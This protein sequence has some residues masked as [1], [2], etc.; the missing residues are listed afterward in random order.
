M[1]DIEKTVMDF[2]GKEI[3]FGERLFFRSKKN[4]VTRL[5]ICGG[6]ESRE[7]LAKC[8][9][10]GDAAKE[11]KILRDCRDRGL[12]VPAPLFRRENV[13]LMEYI[14]GFPLSGSHLKEASFIVLLARWMADFHRSFAGEE[15][16]L[17]KRDLRLH[18]F[19]F[20]GV[21]LWGIDF[22]ESETGEAEK[23]LADLG[24]S[25]L[26]SSPAFTQGNLKRF[27]RFL[28]EYS[29]SRP[30]EFSALS[31]FLAVALR[32]RARYR[33]DL[34]RSCQKWASLLESGE[35]VIT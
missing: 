30:T 27:R 17:L 2:F 20:D 3:T 16:T 9:I 18:N 6:D 22:E 1:N 19:I 34:E 7:I 32:E 28:R 4:Q 12:T 23:D 35:S 11:E 15:R 8:F 5:T 26:E 31:S 14:R 13:L 10:W 29:K 24:A 25:F 33:K 21:T